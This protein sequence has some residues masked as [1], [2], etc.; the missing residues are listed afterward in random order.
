V[1][2]ANLFLRFGIALAIGFMI[3]LQREYAFQAAGRKLMAGERTFAL[4]GIV[5]ALAAMS[6]D[7]LNSSLAFF[8]VILMVGVFIAVAYFLDAR[9]GHIRPDYRELCVDHR[10]VWSAVLLELPVAGCS[11]RHCHDRTASLKLETDRL[12]KALTRQDI[13]AALQLAIISLIILPILPNE[14]LLPPPSTCSTR[15]KSG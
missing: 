2:P 12:V 14:S 6:A 1:N 9:Q 13:F 11:H 5:G 7:I 15:S 8:V 3:G 4:M 10:F